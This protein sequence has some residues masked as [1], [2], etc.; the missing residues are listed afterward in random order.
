MSSISSL[1]S[2]VSLPDLQL[3]KD[4]PSK[5]DKSG[6]V[7][8]GRQGERALALNDADTTDTSKPG[9]VQDAPSS[10]QDNLLTK[11]NTLI[12]NE[13]SSGKLTSDRAAALRD[14]FTH[15]FAGSP[16]SQDAAE[17]STSA[18]P[19]TESASTSNAATPDSG[20]SATSA[21]NATAATPAGSASHDVGS[22][23]NDFLKLL[24]DAK[25][26]A[27]TYG[28]SGNPNANSSASGARLINY[29]A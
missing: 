10:S 14:V 28:A 22:V 7:N 11:I 26:T 25:S 18:S 13:L 21:A 3:L 4:G 24:Q 17:D 19:S 16:D 5:D 23:L 12:S 2:G 8:A 15:A 20:N 27:S 1:G 9:E 29:R 6:T